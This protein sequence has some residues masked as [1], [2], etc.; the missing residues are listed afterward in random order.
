ML[1][2]DVLDFRIELTAPP[3]ANYE[4]ILRAFN[5]RVKRIHRCCMNDDARS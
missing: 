5:S 1:T 2:L 4:R 3:R